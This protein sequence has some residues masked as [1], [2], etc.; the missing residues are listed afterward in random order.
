M[1]DIKTKLTSGQQFVAELNSAAK[2]KDSL[3]L[4]ARDVIRKSH[5]KRTFVERDLP[6]NS[7]ALDMRAT[8]AMLNA[9]S[10]KDLSNDQRLILIK[11]KYQ[12]QGFGDFDKDFRKT[13]PQEYGVKK[14]TANAKVAYNAEFIRR[15]TTHSY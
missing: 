14:E 11:Q 7:T 2:D 15:Q 9:Y 8:Y 12:K 3:L 4:M 13:F 5:T 10:R 1:T 6:E